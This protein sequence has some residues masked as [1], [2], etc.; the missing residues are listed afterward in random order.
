M[1]LFRSTHHDP[2]PPTVV[3]QL[4]HAEAAA[5][6]L[7]ELQARLDEVAII[8][9]FALTIQ[10]AHPANM[11]NRDQIDLCLDLRSALAPVESHVPVIPGRPQP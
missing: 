5:M 6:A 4:N 8:V 9:D 3:H 1:G 11:R 10:A 2:D 7:A